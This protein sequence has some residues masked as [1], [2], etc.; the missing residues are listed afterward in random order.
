MKMVPKTIHYMVTSDQSDVFHIT[1][2]HGP[3]S[4]VD[5]VSGLDKPSQM[6]SSTFWGKNTQKYRNKRV[7][8]IR[9]TIIIIFIIIPNALNTMCVCSIVLR[10]RTSDEMP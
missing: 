1:L 7:F 4:H 10:S 9:R 2:K 6:L 3:L 8:I 5:V